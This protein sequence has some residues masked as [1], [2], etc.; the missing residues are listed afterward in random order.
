M[1]Y[2]DHGYIAPEYALQGRFSIKSDVYGYGVLSLEIITSQRNSGCY[3]M[4]P[5][6][7]LIG[8]VWELWKEGRCMDIVDKSMDKTY[9]EEMV[10]RCIQIGLLCVQRYASDRPTMSKAVF[11]LGNADV[12]LPF[13]KQPAFIDESDYNGDIQPASNRTC[14]VNRVTI[15]VVEAR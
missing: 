9:S 7:N 14:S 2:T 15:S 1:A 4:N 10:V 13:P 3:Q 8:H 11:M 6:C 12:V 5:F